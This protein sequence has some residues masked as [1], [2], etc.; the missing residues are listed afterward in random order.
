[1]GK[2]DTFDY[3][4]TFPDVGAYW[5]HPHISEERQQELGLYGNILVIPAEADFTSF[6]DDIFVVLDDI[7]LETDGTI[8]AFA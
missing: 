4:L 5:Y 1:M 8:S 6:E 7:R 3:E 2:G